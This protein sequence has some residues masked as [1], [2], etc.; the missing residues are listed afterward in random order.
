AERDGSDVITD[1]TADDQLGIRGGITI[2]SEV[3]DGNTLVYTSDQL[4]ATLE[5]YTGSLEEGTNYASYKTVLLDAV[6][7]ER[8]KIKYEAIDDGSGLGSIS[9]TFKNDAGNSFTVSDSTDIGIAYSTISATQPNGSY[10]LHSISISDRAYSSNIIEYYADG[11]NSFYNSAEGRW[12]DD[13]HEVDFSDYVVN[14]TGG[15]EPQTDFTPPELLSIAGHV[16][17]INSTP[18]QSEPR[19]DNPG[20]EII[21][22]GQGDDL[23]GTA[24][25]DTI[26]GFSGD[27]FIDGGGGNDRVYGGSG[28]DTLA[29]SGSGAAILRGGEGS[30]TLRLDLTD[31]VPPSED[32]ITE[33][34]LATGKSG[35]FGI[36]DPLDDKLTSIE[37]IDYRGLIDAYLGGNAEANIISGGGG[38]DVIDGGDGSD[39]LTG[40]DGSDIFII[41]A[42]RDGSD[43]ITDFTADDQLGIRGGIT[44]RS[45]VVDG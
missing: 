19:V 42:E 3:V 29:I 17:Q 9:F 33:V 10:S 6:A 20:D 30:D 45:E 13:T 21:G 28:D 37:N 1:F 8:F 18:A 35:A 12:L 34:N 43:V 41:R 36:E 23:I 32:F 24:D 7:G 25:D 31:W 27:D 26:Y 15:Q 40:G 5:G 44:I 38:D 39:Q 4:L 22:T 11:R 2:R 16:A 14:V